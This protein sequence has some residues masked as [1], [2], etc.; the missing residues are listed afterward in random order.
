MLAVLVAVSFMPAAAS[1]ANAAGKAPAKPKLKTLKIISKTKT[2]VKVKVSWG[3]AKWAKK[4]SVYKKTNKGK[5]KKV[6]T[7]KKKSYTF[8]EKRAENKKSVYI[9]VRAYKGHR[10]SKFSKTR[11]VKIPAKAKTQSSGAEPVEPE[12]HRG[13]TGKPA[14]NIKIGKNEDSVL[15][16]KAKIAWGG[17]KPGNWTFFSE[18]DSLDV[19]FYVE[20]KYVS[21]TK[22]SCSDPDLLTISKSTE[23]DGYTGCSYVTFTLKKPVKR[24]PATV[25]FY[26]DGSLIYSI[27]VSCAHDSIIGIDNSDTPRETFVPTYVNYK[28]PN[29]ETVKISIG[30]DFNEIKDKLG[31]CDSGEPYGRIYC[32]IYTYGGNQNGKKGDFSHYLQLY[33]GKI[34]G[35]ERYQGSINNRVIGWATTQ[36]EQA[37]IGNETIYANDSIDKISRI[38]KSLDRGTFGDIR[39]DK[40]KDIWIDPLQ[41]IKGFTKKDNVKFSIY[42]WGEAK[43]APGWYCDNPAYRVKGRQLANYSKSQ[44][45]SW[46]EA[47]AE[48]MINAYRYAEGRRVLPP[49]HRITTVMGGPRTTAE[50]QCA[51]YEKYN[52][53]Y[54][55][56]HWSSGILYPELK[57]K[58][59]T[60][61]SKM[62]KSA[63]GIRSGEVTQGTANI[64]EGVILLPINDAKDGYM[65]AEAL[66]NKD[67]YITSISVGMSNGVSVVWFGDG[68]NGR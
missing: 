31:E 9:K 67:P 16:G 47:I 6:K 18:K 32:D 39:R 19:A 48:N 52:D 41:E 13:N 10:K 23:K 42:Y 17:D 25:D 2:N 64:G 3:K 38:E 33:V 15:E 58:D 60:D 28:K 45:A 21:K 53:F 22:A 12:T 26:F 24:G 62:V 51:Y 55:P 54:D 44:V 65:H 36:K 27:S 63:T 30:Q 11:K 50:D 5:W 37:N 4:Y 49:E 59:A 34:T 43:E 1:T 46:E 14:K 56:D 68:F 7:L 35:T 57:D 61:R 29:G 40:Y 8:K 20:D 66:Q